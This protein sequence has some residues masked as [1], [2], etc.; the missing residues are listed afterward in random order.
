MLERFD[1][2]RIFKIIAL[3]LVTLF[4]VGFLY[5]VRTAVTPFA[6]ALTIAYVLNPVV[7]F[8][9]RRRMT[10]IQ[11]I[12]VTYVVLLIVVGIIA[13]FVVPGLVAEI[14]RLVE[15]V[16]YYLEHTQET[17]SQLERFYEAT[18]MP[19]M[20]RDAVNQALDR[21]LGS[22]EERLNIDASL[23]AIMARLGGL[24]GG[25]FNLILGLVLAVYF[26]KDSHHF[27]DRFRNMLPQN[28]RG[29]VMDF[30]AD[31]N[32]VLSGF[33]HGRLIVSAIVGV[34]ATVILALLGVRFYLVLGLFAGLTNI[35]PYFGP[36]IGGIPAV[37][38]AAMDSWGLMFRVIITYLLIQHVDGFILTPRTLSNRTGLH[39]IAVVFAILAGAVLL[40][41]WGLFL[42]VPL[43]AII[44]VCLDYVFRWIAEGDPV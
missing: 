30:L 20:V 39:P 15:N 8:A 7:D 36:F 10:R 1:W 28:Y 42:G 37:I 35:I 29:Y 33:V 22:L 31:V 44:K 17:I 41:F 5:R 14:N 40:G 18:A 25:L 16:P 6:I 32:R 19:T 3:L 26:L 21:Y 12:A 38:V 43:A 27:Y 2:F 24:F 13:L 11:A 9:E 4:A 34:L 23:T